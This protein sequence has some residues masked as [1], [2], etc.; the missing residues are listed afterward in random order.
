M[1][2][3]LETERLRLRR[4]TAADADLLVDL[5]S[6]PAVMAWITG[7]RTTP[8]AIRRWVAPSTSSVQR[9]SPPGM[10]TWIVFS[11]W[12]VRFSSR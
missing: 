8:R 7:G 4:F 10:S 3:L 2:V 6:D 12:P 5:D 1:H 9:S 11:V